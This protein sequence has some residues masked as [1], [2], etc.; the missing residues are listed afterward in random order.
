[1]IAEKTRALLSKIVKD[2]KK[3]IFLFGI[4]TNVVFLI[5]YGFRIYDNLNHTAFLIAYSI[6][7]L[8]SLIGFILHLAKLKKRE[9]SKALRWG[10]F[11]F[12]GVVLAISTYEIV[13]FNG[14]LFDVIMLITSASL[15]S[16]LIIL[17]IISFVIQRYIRRFAVAVKNDFH[18]FTHR[19]EKQVS[20][21][22]TE[23]KEGELKGHS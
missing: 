20:N 7:F 9:V 13:A 8:I 5:F 15:W 14:N 16:F 17:E 2:V 10:K 21:E 23:K 12:K 22:I 3:L 18:F 19:E 11:L 6:I 1:M 4:I